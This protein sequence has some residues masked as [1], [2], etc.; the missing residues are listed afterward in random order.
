M[1]RRGWSDG[2]PSRRERA[3]PL[4]AMRRGVD[5]ETL[6]GVVAAPE[7]VVPVRPGREIRQSQFS[8]EATGKLY[9]LR[10][11]VETGSGSPIVITLYRT[12][13]IDKYWRQP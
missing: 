7:Q 10:V 6:L 5:Q 13:K 2:E 3:C 4:A 11:V 8:D 1:M 12:S 9:L